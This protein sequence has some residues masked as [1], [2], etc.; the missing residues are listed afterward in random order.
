MLFH[1]DEF[2]PTRQSTTPTSHLA[3]TTILTSPNPQLPRRPLRR[4]P[5]RA[6]R[7]RAILPPTNC[8]LPDPRIRRNLPLR[9]YRPE[10]RR[11]RRRIQ[12]SLRRSRLPSIVRRSRYRGTDVGH[13]IQ[14]G[15]VVALD[16]VCGVW[17]D[18]A[19]CYCCWVGVTDVSF[20]CLSI[21]FSLIALHKN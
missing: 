15:F 7:P 9:H 21:C 2:W 3:Q 10:S 5:H 11:R 14:E 20:S 18:D 8:R 1:T 19:G 12:H 16:V 4:H 6:T 17:F 13:S